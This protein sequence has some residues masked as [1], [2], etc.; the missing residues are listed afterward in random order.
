MTVR[1]RFC[2]FSKD[3]LEI[4]FKPIICYLQ[5]FDMETSHDVTN[6]VTKLRS[7]C[8]TNTVVCALSTI[9]ELSTASVTTTAP[10]AY[11]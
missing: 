10:V 3:H 7:M 5:N 2:Q 9:C 8:E 11:S 4:I 6:A 1:S